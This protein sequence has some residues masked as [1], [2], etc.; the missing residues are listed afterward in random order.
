MWITI[1]PF[2]KYMLYLEYAIQ[3][4]KIS[5]PQRTRGFRFYDMD[6]CVFLVCYWFNLL[7]NKVKIFED[8]IK[9]STATDKFYNTLAN[10]VFGL[11]FLC[12]YIG[13]FITAPAVMFTLTI[14]FLVDFYYKKAR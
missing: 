5:L 13:F 2:L 7:S 6:R 12:V 11:I 10:V 9:T 14:L 8:S 4:Y 3:E 1:L